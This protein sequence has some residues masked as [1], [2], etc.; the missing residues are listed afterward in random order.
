MPISL[1]EQQQQA[2]DQTEGAVLVLSGA[3]TGKTRV[4]TARLAHI[5]GN[6]LARPWECLA[7]TFTNR[8]AREMEERLKSMIGADASQTWL[9]TFHSICLKILRRFAGELGYAQNFVIL[10]EDDQTRLIK[11]IMVSEGYDIKKYTPEAVLAAIQSWKDKGISPDK[12]LTGDRTDFMGGR[13]LGIYR[14]YQD[15]LK[16][17][18]AMDFGDLLLLCLE[19]FTRN[20]EVLAKYQNQFRYIMVDEYQ[21]TNTAQYLWLRLLAQKWGN[22]CCV[23]DDDQSIYSWRGAQISNILKFDH[24]F[25]DAKI[26]RLESNYRSTAHILAAASGIIR[27]NEGRLGKELRV[28]PNR[29]PDGEK[30]KVKGLSSGREEAL[31]AVDSIENAYR[32]GTPYKQM[33]ILVRTTAQTREFEETFITNAIP[34]QVIGGAKFYEREEIRDAIAYLRAVTLPSDD[35]AIMRIINKPRRGIGDTTIDLVRQ[36]ALKENLSFFTAL[37]DLTRPDSFELKPAAKKAAAAF[38]QSHALWTEYAEKLPPF[39]ALKNILDNAGYIAMWQESTDIK[40]EGKLENLTELLSVLKQR[41]DSI[42]AF[43]EHIALISDT[44]EIV[45]DDKVSIMTLH[46]A[47]GLEFDTVILA[48]WEEGLFPHQRALDETGD[49][50]LE[51]ERRLAYVGITR[52]RKNVYITYAANRMVFGQWQT[53]IPSR[54]LEELPAAD[55]EILG[56]PAS[57]KS[58]SNY[59][60]KIYKP[61]DPPPPPRKQEAKGSKSGLRVGIRVK[62]ALFGYGVIMKID[63]EKL[64][65]LFENGGKKNILASFVTTA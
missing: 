21:D 19:L 60:P 48:G 58:Y 12:V 50:G 42:P 27:H 41:F 52:A 46:S 4:L 25:K 40:A 11:Q 2:V 49:F 37:K 5:I 47:K 51:E 64:T 7:V 16:S 9:G 34:Y 45:G 22:L 1:N 6:G 26:I 36:K 17:M 33:A 38:L 53:S 57:F 59:T 13:V 10:G 18:N 54:F 63:G 44:D 28:A 55:I 8:A 3:G 30:V 15:R 14:M 20:P 62:H 32:H 24:D 39:E 65:V 43:L 56:L 31:A 29:D 61:T 23:G 35:M